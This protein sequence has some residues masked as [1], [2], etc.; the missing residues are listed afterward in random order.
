[1]SETMLFSLVVS[2][3]LIVIYGFVKR[4]KGI[5]SELQV[6]R[7]IRTVAGVRVESGSSIPVAMN[8]ILRALAEAYG[9]RKGR[10]EFRERVLG[11][12]SCSINEDNS[13]SPGLPSVAEEVSVTG[14]SGDQE[15]GTQGRNG[16]I[17]FAIEDEDYACRIELQSNQLLSYDEY[18]NVEVLV[19]DKISRCLFDKLGKT[20]ETAFEK[21]ELPFAIVDSSGRV[22]FKNEMFTLNF[23]GKEKLELSEDIPGLMATRRDTVIVS[24]SN[25][26]GEG[27]A[28][29]RDTV[30]HRIG[31]GLF[32]VFSPNGLDQIPSRSNIGPASLIFDAIDELNI[33]IV[34]LEKDDSRPDREFRIW[35]INKAFYRIFGL[36]GSN[37]QLEEVDEIISTAVGPELRKNFLGKYF[38]GD[39]IYMRHDGIKVRARLTAVKGEEG[40]L[41]VVFEPAENSQLLISSYRR[42]VNAADNLFKSGDVRSFLMELRDATRS[43]GITLA[44]KHKDSLTFELTDKSGFVVNVP[45]LVYDD[46]RTKDLLNYQG[47]LIVPLKHGESVTGALVALRPSEEGTELVVAGARI[48]EAHEMVKRSLDDIHFYIAKVASEARRADEANRFKSE[49]LANMSHEIRTPLNSIIGF[50]N[51]IHDDAAE[52]PKD[53]LGE[54]SGNIVTA[55]NHLLSLIN[56]I[57]DLAKVETGKMEMDAHEFSVSD[58]IEGVE[59]IL[60]PVL[61]TKRVTLNINIEE[62]VKTFVAD[63]VKFKQ[64]LY[65]L[66]NNAVNFSREDNAV[67]LVI[68]KSASG[69]EMKVIDRGVGIRRDDL[70][71]LFKPFVQ[72]AGEKG[73]TGLGL[74]LTKRLVELHGGAIRVDS[75]FGLGTTVTVYL[76]EYRFEGLD[77]PASFSP[78]AIGTPQILS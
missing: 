15:G 6:A 43:D 35:S 22:I 38:T 47:Y 45:Q 49:F 29:L 5:V 44:R 41:V 3:L 13:L 59:R 8:K 62:R 70:D 30:V 18:R 53:T 46:L 54:F 23:Q 68:V 72:L 55:G 64:I 20:V 7:R 16:Q 17:V 66:L 48:L 4:Q 78:G 57:L 50:A 58:V 75:T 10:L 65:N 77:K 28:N 51:I 67:D 39:F 71:K 74:Q 24:R 9:A 32:A 73:G 26:N 19:K 52:L 36:V 21:S 63:P 34:I 1:M 40:S 60:K 69:I 31:G 14:M 37:A 27:E 12:F 42:F 25:L 11:N 2:L 33:G 61:H 76:P 56:D